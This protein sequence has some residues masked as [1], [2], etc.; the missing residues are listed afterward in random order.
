MAKVKIPKTIAGVKVPKK[1][2][3]TAKKAIKGAARPGVRRIAAAAIDAAGRAGAGA[4]RTTERI[5]WIEAERIG[6]AF[7][8]AAI[9]G[10]RRFLEGFEEGLRNVQARDAKAEPRDDA[11]GTP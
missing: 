9:D 10:L 4:G 1:L 2:R 5:V 3:K 7:R 8:T 11:S 6:D